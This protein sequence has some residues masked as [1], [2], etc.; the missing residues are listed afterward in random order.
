M[1]DYRRDRKKTHI[2]RFEEIPAGG[3][4][5]GRLLRIRRI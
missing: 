2:V 3:I 1:V 5:A 4:G